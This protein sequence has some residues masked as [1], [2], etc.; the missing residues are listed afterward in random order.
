MI[1]HPSFARSSSASSSLCTLRGMVVDGTHGPRPR[2]VKFDPASGLIVAVQELRS[3]DLPQEATEEDLPSGK[4]Y[5]FGPQDYILAG[6]GD[7]HVHARE[8]VSGKLNDVEDFVSAGQAALA[9]GITYFADMPN[10]P[11]PPID[12][13]SYLAKL[14]LTG[15]AGLPIFLYAA[16]NDFTRPLSFAVPYKAF[17]TSPNVKLALTKKD[18]LAFYRQAWVSFHGEDQTVVANAAGGATHQLRRPVQAEVIAI[19]NI[20]AWAKE[21]SLTARICH[22]TSKDALDVILA[23]QARDTF[24]RSH[25][26]TEVTLN[27]LC[28]S[29]ANTDLENPMFNVNPPLRAECHRQ[30]LWAA[31]K[32]G[33]IQIL[34]TDHAPHPLAAKKQGASGLPGLECWAG[35]LSDLYHQALAE[36]MAADEVLKRI[37]Q[38]TAENPAQWVNNFLPTWQR[39]ALASLNHFYPQLGQGLGKIAPGYSASFSIL[40]FASP[41]QFQEGDIKS[42]MRWSPWLGHEFSGGL[43]GIFVQG[44]AVSIPH[45][46]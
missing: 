46:N 35:I 30:A 21:F 6:L 14:A 9:G 32:N 3:A 8:D 25:L 17:L 16:L 23:A 28:F 11:L 41:W 20:L 42:K 5:A 33:Q 31:W 44:K 34:A 40:N 10:N 36:G 2:E 18:N 26:M 22:V 45:Q 39:A 29:D 12:D 24:W 38:T 13:A 27:H 7:L 1:K 43:K 4:L 37:A 19:Q 15:R